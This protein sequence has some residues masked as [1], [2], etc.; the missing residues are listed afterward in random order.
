MMR[1]YK[2][3][4]LEDGLLDR[5]AIEKI[6]SEIPEIKVVGL[7]STTVQ[8]FSICE[9]EKP[10]LIIADAKIGQEKMAGAA[11]VKSIRKLLPEV[12]ILGMTY[13]P[14]LVD[15]LRRA[16]CDHVVN[17]ALIES[18][19]AARKY[20]LETLIPRPAYYRDFEPPSLTSQQDR[21]LRLICDGKTEAEIAKEF[22]Y[23]NRKPIRN[24][25]NTLFDIFGAVSV[26]NLVHL[27]YKTGYL[28]PDQD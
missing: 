13:H 19:E 11:F 16:G 5:T 1:T 24:I 28:N 22:G 7:A 26:A 21:V 23:S 9:K 20:I 8:A 17:K 25:K 2:T 18:H 4:I 15:G 27:A 14:D 6:L 10:D 12:R 3:F